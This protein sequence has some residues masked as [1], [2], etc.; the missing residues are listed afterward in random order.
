M[1]EQEDKYLLFC[2]FLERH[3]RFIWNLCNRRADGDLAVGLDYVQEIT[4]LLWLQQDKLRP[5]ATQQHERTWIKMIAHDYFRNLSQRKTIPVEPFDDD[6][7]PAAAHTDDN[8]PA[9][10]LDEYMVCL[11]PPERQTVGLYVQGYKTKEIAQILE[12][13]AAAV[14]QRLHRAVGHMKK[15]AGIKND[16]NQ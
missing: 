15:Y 13:S 5:E 14:R 6:N 12:T 4:I 2:S 11:P 1:E 7:L 10:L 16:K 3:R 9:R 8:S